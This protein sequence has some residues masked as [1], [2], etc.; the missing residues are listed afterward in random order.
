M[1]RRLQVRFDGSDLALPATAPTA[2]PA[3]MPAPTRPRAPAPA[4]TP[5]GTAPEN[6]A[7]PPPAPVRAADPAHL[8]GTRGCRSGRGELAVDR[9]GRRSAGHHACARQNG[10]GRRSN[11]ELIHSAPRSVLVFKHAA[12]TII[13]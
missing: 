8:L 13:A 1:V 10:E 9:H 7:W 2:V 3:A 5:D 4:R 11:P 6:R 12:P